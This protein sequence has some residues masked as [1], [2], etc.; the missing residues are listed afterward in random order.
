[1][2]PPCS[3]VSRFFKLASTA[4]LKSKRIYIIHRP[5]RQKS[6][7]QK[8]LANLMG[9]TTNRYSSTS[10]NSNGRHTTK[11]SIQ[12]QR[13]IL[14][15][16]GLIT[17]GCLP[18]ESD[19]LTL[20]RQTA[21]TSLSTPSSGDDESADSG[22]V[23]L[24]DSSR[25][26]FGFPRAIVTVPSSYRQHPSNSNSNKLSGSNGQGASQIPLP[27]QKN[28]SHEA[29]G[30]YSHVPSPSPPPSPHGR[31]RLHTGMIRLTCPLLVRDIDT[32]ER[33]K[34]IARFNGK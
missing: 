9:L 26:R 23:L 14:L 3:N 28:Q 15:T 18:T 4:L 17:N 31:L 34:G 5:Y 32:L 22:S 12:Q 29:S 24:V 11:L 10:S 30:T 33:N 8:P 25:C 20:Q 7:N 19:L 6:L 13:D 27:L 1:M 2:L 21:Y 16:Q